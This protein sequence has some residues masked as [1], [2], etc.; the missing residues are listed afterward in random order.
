MS[1]GWCKNCWEFP[2]MLRCLGFP[3]PGTS[4]LL[5]PSFFY[6]QNVNTRFSP[7]VFRHQLWKVF[8]PPMALSKCSKSFGSPNFGLY[9]LCELQFYHFIRI[10]RTM[11]YPLL[12]WS[13]PQGWSPITSSFSSNHVN[14]EEFGLFT[15]EIRRKTCLSRNYAHFLPFSCITHVSFVPMNS[16]LS[17]IFTRVRTTQGRS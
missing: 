6:K 7:P 1:S 4:K 16:P 2:R 13:P 15:A 3:S 5:V 14:N 12:L 8:L 10:F 11:S 9:H 17:Y